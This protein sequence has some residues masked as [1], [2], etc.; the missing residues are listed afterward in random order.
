MLTPATLADLQQIVTEA[1]ATGEPLEVL[2]GGS[3]CWYGRPVASRQALTMARFSGV[4]D[5]QP[6]E[7]ICI[8]RPGTPLS[9][10]ER[11]LDEQGQMLAF[12]PPHWGDAATLGGTVGCNLS[13]PRRFKAGA[14]RDHLLG[15]QAVTGRGEAIRGGGK[16][17]KNVTGYDL[18]KLMCGSF[19]TLAVFTELCLKV[20]PR[21]ESERTVVVPGLAEPEALALLR[22]VS[23]TAH[24]PS[25]LACL[26]AG[27]IMPPSLLGFARHSKPLALIR[28]EGPERSVKSRA[29][30]TAAMA[31]GSPI[32]LERIA[33]RGLW[34]SL[35]ELEPLPVGTGERLW[36]LSVPPSRGHA[37]M[38]ALRR[39]GATRGFYDWS[40]GLVWALLPATADGAAHA[41][42]W[43]AG[44][45]ARVLR[46][47]VGAPLP[48]EVFAPLP[49]AQRRLHEQLKR[50]F[51][52][53][54]ILNP[55]RMYAGL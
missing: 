37:A 1:A 41:A 39:A 52:P 13:G 29:E 50:A 48:G 7:L 21:P 54:G 30:A 36:R 53:S 47:G 26:P 10:L 32:I 24:E 40:G 46:S 9:A 49:E 51:D 2:G 22:A 38:E 45:H 15:F 6:E 44:G 18:S 8:A 34:R 43:A 19:G 28:I 16:V 11:M 42:A 12:E 3:K 55:G 33:S 25:G 4:V 20:L 27:T 35:R 17:V 14:A 5:Y 31:H 23:R